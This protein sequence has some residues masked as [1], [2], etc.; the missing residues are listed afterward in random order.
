MESD[1]LTLLRN[2]YNRATQ[3]IAD[4]EAKINKAAKVR[5]LLSEFLE[6]PASAYLSGIMIEA[7]FVGMKQVSKG[8]GQVGDGY[9]RDM[10]MLLSQLR[11]ANGHL[12]RLYLLAA[13]CGGKLHL[14]EI[15]E[16]L[17]S[18]GFSEAKDVDTLVKNLG[19]SINKDPKFAPDPLVK[20]VYYFLP[21]RHPPM[22]KDVS[23]VDDETDTG[24]DVQP[25]EDSEQ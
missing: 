2:L 20:R 19:T 4:S 23:P 8:N 12:P 24:L 17:L 11:A 9:F 14:T 1:G 7:G 21:L 10:K 5:S 15:S 22:P 25:V 13:A 6:D 3:D 18:E 16:F